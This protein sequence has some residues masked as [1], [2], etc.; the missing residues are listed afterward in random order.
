MNLEGLALN[1]IQIL[2]N[3]ICRE[4]QYYY[5]HELPAL[6]PF[7]LMYQED[8]ERMKCKMQLKK[9]QLSTNTVRSPVCV[10]D[11]HKQ[12]KSKLSKE[13]FE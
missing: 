9:K 2:C 7:S 5:I 12:A 13:G 8:K 3:K 6:E 4:C 1:G 11:N 10:L